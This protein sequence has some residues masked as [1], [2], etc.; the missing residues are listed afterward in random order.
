MQFQ[1]IRNPPL[2]RLP[3]LRPVPRLL[4]DALHPALVVHDLRVDHAVADRLAHDVLRVL[5]RVEVQLD[6]DVAERDARV[7]ERE[8]ADARLD[9]VLTQP[10][11]ERLG[12]VGLELGG[13]GSEG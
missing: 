10:D 11:D 2:K 12:A 5:L 13:V 6:A 7:G 1:T 9:N 4:P 8:A 3:H